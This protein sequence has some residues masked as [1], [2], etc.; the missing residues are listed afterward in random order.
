MTVA[1]VAVIDRNAVAFVAELRAYGFWRVE[2]LFAEL[3]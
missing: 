2:E 3:L 1:D